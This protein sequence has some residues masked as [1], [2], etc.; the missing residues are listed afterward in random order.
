MLARTGA[1]LLELLIPS[2]CPC[3]DAPRAEGEPLLCAEC[4]A[5]LCELRELRGVATAFAYEQTAERLIL[6]HKFERRTDALC[7]LLEAL[8]ARISEFPGAGLVAVPRH[9]A[10]IR[11]LGCDPVHAL[12]RALGRRTQRPVWD[13]VLYRSRRTPPQT[14]F[15]PAERRTNVAGSFAARPGSLRG[16]DVLLLDDVTTT[17]ATLREA[18][19]IVS[20]VAQARSV[21]CAALAGTALP[22]PPAP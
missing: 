17:G 21:R 7:V 12:A 9:P 14:G 4:T 20:A 15:S 5:G 10:R 2:R 6:R 19:R 1:A 16:R 18:A 11:E 3:C 8:A 13:G 22:P